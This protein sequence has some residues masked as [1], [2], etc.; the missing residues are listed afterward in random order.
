VP[1][2]PDADS[3]RRRAGAL[4]RLAGR[5][6][7]TPLLS[8]HRWADDGT[9]TSPR[10]ETCREQL[11]SDQAGIRSAADDLRDHAWHFERRAEAL[12]AAAVLA[13]LAGG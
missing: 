2:D 5:L 7:D 6:D 10:V 9:W 12:D 13:A 4:R 1:T 8:L 11:A 3:Y